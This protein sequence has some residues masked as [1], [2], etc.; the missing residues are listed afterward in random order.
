MTIQHLLIVAGL[1]LNLLPSTVLGDTEREPMI[2]A[3]VQALVA[4]IRRDVLQT[5]SYT[6]R[7]E[8]NERVMQA[9]HDVPGR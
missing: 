6:G 9:M 1:F 5:R 7:S 8:L 4:E 2:E 3:K